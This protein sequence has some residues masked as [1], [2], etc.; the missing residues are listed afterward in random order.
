MRV[1]FATAELSPVAAVGGLASAAAGLVHELRAAGVEMLVALPDYGGVVLDGEESFDLPVPSWAAP[2]T[3]RVGRHAVAGELHLVSVPGM[4]R[5]HP[6]QQPDGSGWPDNDL[7]FLAFSAAV[8]GLWSAVGADV[9]HLNDWHTA[10][11]LAALDDES[12]SVV[13]IH[14]L[15]YQGVT[16]GAWLNVLGPRAGAYEWFGR[17]NPLKGALVLADAIV[18]VS[19]T[20]AREILDPANGFGLDGV[21]RYRA[22]A[23]RGI[24]NG[25]D[26]GVWNPAADPNLA[27]P[28]DA[29]DLAG[30][31]ASRTALLERLGLEGG[32]PL[33]VLVT[34]LTGQKGTDLLADLV[35]YLRHLPLRLG[36]LGSGDAAT[37]A[38]LH[39]AATEHPD[40]VAFAEGYDEALSHQLFGG[41]DLLLMPS[42]F[43][44]CG[45]SQMQAMRYGTLPVV[46]DVGGLHDT[47][48]D[49]D[50]HPTTGTGFLAAAPEVVDLV[51]ALH[52]GVRAWQDPARRSALQQRGMRADW[53]WQEPARQHLAL[54][55]QVTS[56]R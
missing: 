51:D 11:A 48:V 4:A 10:V 35:P 14:N 9:L 32:A 44:P 39:E 13:S 2:A 42:R 7:R 41:G 33:G 37:A 55:R 8:A 25:I 24:R 45:L 53:S 3:V 31:V 16:S 21:L 27:S 1:L 54:Y 28:Y 18:A 29:G 20:Y 15:A 17:C 5:T 22:G 36:I 47:V 6:Y 43:E 34:R 26:T 46:T 56:M 40:L 52:R 38:T 19:P 30:K 50:A 23:L 12:P 49:A